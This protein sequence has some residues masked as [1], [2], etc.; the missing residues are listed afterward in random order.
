MIDERT[1]KAIAAELSIAYLAAHRTVP[2]SSLQVIAA[3]IADSVPAI[4]AENAHAVFKRAMQVEAIPTVPTLTDAAKNHMAESYP[5]TDAPALEFKDPRAAWLPKSQMK[6]NINMTTAIK[7]LSAAISDR[8]YMEYCKVHVTKTE[9]RGDKEVT[10]Y[11]NLEAALAFDRPKKAMLEDLYMKY[12]RK[13]SCAA[14]YPANAPLN[15]GLTPPTVPE[16]KAML[17][18]E[19]LAHI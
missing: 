5:Q 13:C 6:R 14:G 8:E 17:H 3:S 19:S 4:T 15:H 12:W 10:V 16:F 2:E 7:N 11:A 18:Y 1:V 9:R